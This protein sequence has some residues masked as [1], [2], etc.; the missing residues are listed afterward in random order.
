MVATLNHLFSFRVANFIWMVVIAVYAFR[1]WILPG[2][3]NAVLEYKKQ[4][5]FIRSTIY[6]LENNHTQLT[7]AIELQEI[8]GKELFIKIGIWNRYVAQQQEEQEQKFRLFD[9]D[10]KQYKVQQH[11]AVARIYVQRDIKED[12]QKVVF[13]KL[14]REYTSATA[15]EAYIEKALHTFTVSLR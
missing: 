6:S 3:Q 8:R 15:Q 13:E 12:L 11:A 9:H 1:R 4:V 14:Q 5:A 2:L 10:L 7:K